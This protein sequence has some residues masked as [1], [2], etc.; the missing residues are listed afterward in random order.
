MKRVPADWEPQRAVWLAWPHNR[1][2]WPG[3]FEPI[4]ECF[5]RIVRLIAEVTRVNVIGEPGLESVA[6][7]KGIDNVDWIPIETNDC[8]I[9]DYG[10]TFVLGDD[11]QSTAIDWGYNA[12]GGKYP[13]WHADDDATAKIIHEA[14]WKRID[15]ALTLEGG[16]LEWDGQGRLLTT[17]ACLVTETRN[18]GLDKQAI[19]N[20]LALL[21]GVREIVWVD[22]GGD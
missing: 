13:P 4:P 20:Q 17:T 18:P 21:T 9:R 1:D 22:G 8:W 6:C 5:R 10:P 7:L 11:G 19:E 16:A 12:W 14:G 2:T 3:R 15:G